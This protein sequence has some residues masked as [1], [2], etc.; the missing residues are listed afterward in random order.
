MS[1][2]LYVVKSDRSDSTKSY[3]TFNLWFKRKRNL[4]QF[5]LISPSNNGHYVVKQG[6]N[7]PF[8][9][10]WGNSTNNTSYSLNIT[11]Q[12]GSLNIPIIQVS[13]LTNTTYETDYS[14]LDDW[15]KKAG[16]AQGDSINLKWAVKAYE[17]SNDSLLSDSL[18]FMLVRYKKPS[19]INENINSKNSINIY[20]N[21]SNGKLT[22][23]SNQDIAN[24]NVFDITG[25]AV[26]N[27]EFTNK[28]NQTEIDLS[29]LNNGI[30]FIAVQSSNGEIS[31]SK[32]VLAK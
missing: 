7:T 21:P 11:P 23:N 20:P 6:D 5:A 25:K 3:Q 30:Y 2:N 4:S 22:I 28:L 16:V 14:Q 12:S 1:C 19:G 8:T 29:A 15:A 9:F 31:K 17:S 26:H 13:N 27:K 18:N 10:A 24:I 32:I